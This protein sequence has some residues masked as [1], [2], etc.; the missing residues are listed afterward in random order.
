[1]EFCDGVHNSKMTNISLIKYPHIS[2]IYYND[3]IEF[4]IENQSNKIYP[5]FLIHN[6]N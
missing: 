4:N 6:Y 1:M 3:I 2:I 5:A